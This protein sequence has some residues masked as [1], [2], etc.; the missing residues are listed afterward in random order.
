MTALAR[1]ILFFSA[2]VPA[3]ALLALRAVGT[4]LSVAIAF[5][6]I[7]LVSLVALVILLAVFRRVEPTELVVARADSQSEQVASFLLAYLLPFVIPDYSDSFTVA[8]LVVFFV[9]LWILYVRGHLVLN[10]VLLL[11]GWGVWRADIGVADAEEI[12][13]VVLIV[14]S[15]DLQPGDKLDVYQVDSPIRVA[16]RRTRDARV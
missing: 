8:A 16:K 3:F 13:S 9:L 12:E 2:W 15:T 14:N 1:S 10:P 6:V 7:A 4:S 5:A 11:L